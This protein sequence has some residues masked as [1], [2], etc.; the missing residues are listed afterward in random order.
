MAVTAPWDGVQSPEIAAFRLYECASLWRDAGDMRTLAKPVPVVRRLLVVCAHPYDATFALGGVIG[1]FVDAG[2]SVHILCLTHGRRPDPSPRRRFERARDLG[3]AARCLGAKDVTLLSHAPA[4]LA[5][6]NIDEITDEVLTAAAGA[7]ALLTIDATGPDTHPDHV[8]A[9]RAA[10]R[11]A[12]KNGSTLYA[13][14]IRPS[15]GGRGR[16]VVV[17]DVNRRRQRDA[18]ECHTGL[19]ADDPLRRR[20]LER[21]D[22]R[23]RLIVLTPERSVAP[24]Y[25]R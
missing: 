4:T 9:M 7:D 8:R 23:E 11:A 18:I 12:T 19:P 21:Q 1:A 3:V 20:W 22:P 25:T 14:T 10:F 13:W 5:A 15:P 2:T 16:E 17:V 24:V 6:A